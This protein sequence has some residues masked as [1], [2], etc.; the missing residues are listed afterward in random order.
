MKT[1]GSRSRGRRRRVEV[2]EQPAE[3]EKP[4]LSTEQ[5]IGA[6]LFEAL[7]AIPEDHKSTPE[8]DRFQAIAVLGS[9][10]N[11]MRA[12]VPDSAKRVV[13]PLE[14]VRWALIELNFGNVLPILR[15]AKLKGGRRPD[16]IARTS[17]RG[18]ASG[19][20]SVLMDLGFTRM[21]AADKVAS[22]LQ[23][24]GLK[25]VKGDTIAQWRDQILRPGEPHR[26]RRAY[27]LVIS[28]ESIALEELHLRGSASEA[29]RNR[30]VK[31]FLERMGQLIE[32]Q[33]IADL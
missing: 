30:Y 32:E 2:V 20:V 14:Q 27:D 25:D 21:A 8:S 26:A 19:A 16:T 1:P 29:A 7:L 17:L 13:V 9:T 28:K 10:I 15:P 5:A 6:Y 31:D 23:E 12:I 33:R 24:K 4:K 18:L 22:L 3:P 11:L